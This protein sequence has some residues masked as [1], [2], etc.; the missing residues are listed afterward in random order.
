M[1]SISFA[2]QLKGEPGTPRKWVFVQLKEDWYVRNNRWKLYRDGNLFDMKDAPFQEIP[3]PDDTD[4]ADAKAARLEL[5]AVL[6]A[7]KPS[8]NKTGDRKERGI[9]NVKKNMGN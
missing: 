5:Q 7:L 2:P 6:D 4:N 9:K 3:V 8:A 1:D